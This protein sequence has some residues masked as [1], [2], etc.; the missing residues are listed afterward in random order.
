MKTSVEISELLALK[1]VLKQKNTQE[2]L[3]VL[4]DAEADEKATLRDGILHEANI[5]YQSRAG[6]SYL[7]KSSQDIMESSDFQNE[8]IGNDAKDQTTAI[9]MRRTEAMKRAKEYYEEEQF[10]AGVRE[11]SEKYKLKIAE[12]EDSLAR[13]VSEGK[14]RVFETLRLGAASPNASTLDGSNYFHGYISALSICSQC[15]TSDRVQA[16]YLC[17][18]PEVRTVFY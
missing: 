4:H 5:F 18:S 9:R 3:T 16:H 2:K 14:L 13:E 7:K 17:S 1:E 11:I 6:I 8:N 15:L 12:V 10:V